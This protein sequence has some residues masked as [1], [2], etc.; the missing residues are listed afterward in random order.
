M[1]DTQREPLRWR[2]H[3]VSGSQ[4]G[5]MKALTQSHAMIAEDVT[6]NAFQT[7]IELPDL[8]GFSTPVEKAVRLLKSAAAIEHALMVQYLYAGYGFSPANRDIISVAIEEMSH[9][10]TVQN[11][12]LLVGGQPDLSRQDF[13]PADSDDSRLFPFDLMLEPV[14]HESLAKYVIAESPQEVPAGVDPA[15]MQR[16]L[17][18]ATQGVGM[19]VNRVGT[20][21]ALLGAV[22]GSETLLLQKAATG[23]PW[24]V[25]VNSLAAEAASL[26]GGRDRVHLPDSAF[27]PMSVAAQGSDSDWD[28]TPVNAALDEFRVHTADGREAALEALRDIGLQG[29]GPSTQPTEVAHFMRFLNLFKR[30]YGAQG[31]GTG[32]ATGSKDIPRASVITVQQ[33]STDPQAISNQETVRWARLANHRYAVL[34]GS[35]EWYLRMPPNERRFL[36]GWCFAEMFALKKLSSIL[37]TKLRKDNPSEGMAAA[38]FTLPPWSGRPV[39]WQDLEAELTS[40]ITEVTAILAGSGVSQEQTRVLIHLK[41]SDE[42]KLAES[43][44]RASGSS[45]RRKSDQAREILDWAAGAADVQSHNGD[46]PPLPDQNQGRFWNLPLADFK[47]T[48]ILGDNIVTPP[49]PGQDAPLINV[50]RTGLMPGG[51]RPKL[52]PTDAE[53]LFLEEWVGNQCPDDPA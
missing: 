15:L 49:G 27:Q 11:L 6:S 44:A 20:L 33:G 18:V 1:S 38:P 37:T 53:F 46:S 47:Q 23:D 9:L 29:E 31:M 4:F 28:R 36:L 10:M 12:L 17:D 14:T 26:Y 25:M 42:R 48:T 41:S 43:T 16:I 5:R 24:Y 13:G 21:Y 30:F 22:F 3:G 19:G 35:L 7:A 50:L 52:K 40:A 2:R 34:L 8:S 39:T 51:R 32:P 45:D